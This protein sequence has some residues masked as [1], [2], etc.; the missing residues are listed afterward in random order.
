[1]R[2]LVLWDVDLTLVDLS[3]VGHSW[4]DQALSEVTGRSLQ[5]LPCCAGRTEQWITTE[6]LTSHGVEASPAMIRRMWDRLIAVAAAAGE[7][8]SASGR[9]LPGAD[10][11]LAA[12]AERSDVVQSLVT[13]NLAEIARHK[14]AAFELDEHIDFE[15]GGYGSLSA[16][17][18][19]LVE[20]AIARATDK[21]GL[22]PESIVVIGDSPHDVTAARRHGATAVGVTTGRSTAAE[23]YDSGADDVLRDLSDTSEVMDTLVAGAAR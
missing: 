3:G 7:T 20:H 12:L 16:L 6:V 11:A 1:M 13:G 4:Y 21:H 8:L 10:R 17:R 14:L 9:A 2:S 19:E 22:A 18:D 15:I 5:E 23:L